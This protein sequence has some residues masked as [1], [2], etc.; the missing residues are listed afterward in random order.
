MAMNMKCAERHSINKMAQNQD[1]V[2]HLQKNAV[3]T[4]TTRIPVE[5]AVSHTPAT[6]THYHSLAI[7]IIHNNNIIIII[8]IQIHLE[9]EDQQ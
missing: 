9:K 6:E 2:F 3:R 4:H 8:T 5:I 7:I 1:V